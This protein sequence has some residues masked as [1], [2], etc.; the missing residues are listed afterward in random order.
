M[1][2]L[3]HLLFLKG[4]NVKIPRNSE[5]LR[6][7]KLWKSDLQ[8]SM[9]SEWQGMATQTINSAPCPDCEYVFHA[10]CWGPTCGGSSFARFLSIA[11][12]LLTQCLQSRDEGASA[13]PRR[14]C[15]SSALP[16]IS[17]PLS[18]FRWKSGKR[19]RKSGVKR[20]PQLFQ[21]KT[22]VE[23]TYQT[24]VTKCLS[25]SYKNVKAEP[26]GFTRSPRQ[27]HPRQAQLSPKPLQMFV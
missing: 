22:L 16:L 10:S 21:S 17:K 23:G 12:L 20:H 7:Q 1:L 4:F 27:S 19:H 13:I 15:N 25:L 26:V 18:G 9:N 6:L 11:L 24:P 5:E 2:F 8:A 14:I 3:G